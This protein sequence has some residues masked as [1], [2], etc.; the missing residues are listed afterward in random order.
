MVHETYIFNLIFVRINREYFL[1]PC[2]S[3]QCLFR[4]ERGRHT[5]LQPF[6]NCMTHN[7]NRLSKYNDI[8]EHLKQLPV[9]RHVFYL[10]C[11]IFLL[12][13]CQFV[14]NQRTIFQPTKIHLKMNHKF[15]SHEDHYN[16]VLR[17]NTKC[18]I[19]NLKYVSSNIEQW[20]YLLSLPA[21]SISLSE[22]RRCM[23]PPID[24]VG[25]LGEK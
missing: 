4:D 25:G 9:A 8:L 19:Q 13:T 21:L 6:I 14:G 10:E 17:M 22:N 5:R 16:R 3:F 11:N 20:F 18:W 2:E 24:A 1:V 15:Q 23:V 7:T 12:K